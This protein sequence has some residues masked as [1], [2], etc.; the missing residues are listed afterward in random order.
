MSTRIL[1]AVLVA[2]LA[3]I[4][5]A[6]AQD[7]DVRIDERVLLVSSVEWLAE[8]TGVDPGPYDL[9]MVRQFAP[10]LYHPAARRMRW[11]GNH[12]GFAFDA[13]V[14]WAL[15]LD[16]YTFEW[17]GSSDPRIVDVGQ[18]RLAKLNGAIREVRDSDAWQHFM[19]VA[20][21]LH[22]ERIALVR[23][24]LSGS[25]AL[26][27]I[28]TFF[29]G[30]AST[31]SYTVLVAPAVGRNNFGLAR[32]EGGARALYYVCN[33]GPLLADG[34]GEQLEKLLLHEFAHS[35]VNPA[36]EANWSAF[37]R[38]EMLFGPIRSVMRS[39]FYTTWE[40]SLDEHI[41]RAVVCEIRSEDGEEDA[42]ECLRDERAR[43]FRYIDVIYASIQKY[44]S[45]R[46]QWSEF[47][48]FVP[49]IADDLREYVDSER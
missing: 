7:L 21:P 48:A 45:D 27:S 47:S 29:G 20:Q 30:D 40:I 49:T 44:Q 32:E 38:S 26:H 10:L 35:F 9:T 12:R 24:A 36:V 4:G 39:Q 33:P 8:P 31:A 3:G 19:R 46:A 14:R 43:G 28:A 23:E 18:R 37:E 22:E 2:S 13:P 34:D 1:I 25:P 16:P 5:V 11:L 6:N 15:E 41:V 42:Q 17:T